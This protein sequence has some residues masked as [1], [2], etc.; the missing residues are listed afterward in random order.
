MNDCSTLSPRQADV[1]TCLATGKTIKEISDQL[2]ISRQMVDVHL[3]AAK[4]KMK[5]ETKEQALATAV[6]NKLIQF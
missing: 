2:G 3:A 6:K 1:L 5:A 4:K